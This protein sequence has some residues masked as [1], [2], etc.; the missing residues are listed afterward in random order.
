MRLR[1]ESASVY[2]SVI[3]LRGLREPVLARMPDAFRRVVTAPDAKPLRHRVAGPGE[4]D[5]WLTVAEALDAADRNVHQADPGLTDSELFGLHHRLGYDTLPV[6]LVIAGDR[7]SV[8]SWHAEFDGALKIELLHRLVDL[9]CGLEDVPFPK[10][11]ALPVLRSA[12]KARAP[13]AVREA[14]AFRAAHPT[15]TQPAPPPTDAQDLRRDVR[16]VSTRLDASILD[17]VRRAGDADA[18]VNSKLIALVAR[19]AGEVY[20][21]SGDPV[22]LTPVHLGRWAGGRVAG[23]FLLNLR[24]GGVR[25]TTWT[26]A[27]VQRMVSAMQ[28]RAGFGGFLWDL[29][30][31][32]KARLRGRSAGEA[33]QGELTVQVSAVRS[34]RPFP[35]EA[36]VDGE[37]SVVFGSIG[38]YPAFFTLLWRI[39][40]TVLLALEDETDRFASDEYL[41]RLERHL[42]AFAGEPLEAAPSPGGTRS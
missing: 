42:R 14:L 32:L 7:L 27:H 8:K 1:D 24:L 15:P 35:A 40:D 6:S 41:P 33:V 11:V 13:L 29:Q 28:G 5:G 2:G 38:P 23:N 26:P 34:P 10:P 30:W 25:S 31:P 17:R 12:V 4:R 22:V 19:T 39:G 16:L 37:P 9:A 21:G 20:R 18:T 36:W 3:I